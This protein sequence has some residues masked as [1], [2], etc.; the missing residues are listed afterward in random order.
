MEGWSDVLWLFLCFSLSVCFF[1]KSLV[2]FLHGNLKRRKAF[3]PV[4]FSLVWSPFYQESF[5]ISNDCCLLAICKEWKV[6][7][8]KQEEKGF[9]RAA[10]CFSGF[11]IACCLFWVGFFLSEQATLT[12]RR[13]VP[14]RFTKGWVQAEDFYLAMKFRSRVQIQGSGLA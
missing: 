9:S 7:A 3:S 11:N 1:N 12:N 6:G 2:L 8:L 10:I 4:A 5:H 14:K 13:G